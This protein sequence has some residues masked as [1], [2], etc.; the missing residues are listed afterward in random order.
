MYM[1]INQI[2]EEYFKSKFAPLFIRKKKLFN[3]IQSWREFKNVTRG[4]IFLVGIIKTV[5]GPNYNDNRSANNSL[6]FN[7]II[8]SF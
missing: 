5:A 7:E 1:K 3:Q 8:K 6:S 2:Y 4:G